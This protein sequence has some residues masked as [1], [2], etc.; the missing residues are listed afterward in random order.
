MKLK[1]SFFDAATFKKDITRF[2]P[3]WALYTVF[4]L[5]V[6][7]NTAAG[8]SYYS[9]PARVL[10][11]S[12][13][14]LALANLLYGALTAQLLFGELFNSR[15][16]NALHAMPVTRQARFGSHILAGIAFAWIPNLLTAL[17]MLSYLG[18]LWYTAFLWLA[19]YSLQYLFFFGVA[20]FSV[21]CTG[22]RFA[23]V[24]VYGI[25]NFLSMVVW[26]FMNTIY[27]PLM[28]GVELDA[29]VLTQF[30]PVA[31]MI[32]STD[33]FKITTPV[34]EYMPPNL[35]TATFSGFGESWPY[36]FMVAG[37]GIVA[38]VG[39]LC[40]YRKRKLESA[41]DF[42]AVSWIEPIFLVLYTLCAGAFLAIFGSLF[43]NDEY[44]FFLALG[45]VI[46]F[47]TGKMLLE[48]TIRVFRKKNFLLAS[49]FTAVMLLTLIPVK[50]DWFGIVSY[51][52]DAQDIA[53]V[54]VRGSNIY[55]DDLTEPEHIE[56]VRQIHGYSIANLEHFK[57]NYCS[58][59]HRYFRIVYHLKNGRTVTRYYYI[60]SYSVAGQLVNELP[61]KA[62]Q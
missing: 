48:R 15:L 59:S 49:V 8:N 34:T 35:D 57:T 18:G 40:L 32:D 13:G 55:R 56:L 31:Q 58:G 5:L 10:N 30:C 1:T 38:L 46:G 47:F 52:P 41:G 22:S 29:T 3:L 12:L 17:L 14:L 36:L 4:L 11:R 39:A 37:I 16:C 60:C 33:Y 54:D 26:W 43:G 61:N 24:L 50:L 53:Y 23:M 6:M 45:M 9:H 62:I 25:I 28:P 42:I 20:V 21:M 2:M 27:S 51:V 19:V 7:L 44:I